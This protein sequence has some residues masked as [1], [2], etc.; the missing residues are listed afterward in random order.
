MRKASATNKVQQTYMDAKSLL[1]ALEEREAEIE[2]SYIVAH[3]ITNP[4]GSTPRK[5][6]LH[7]GRS[8][9]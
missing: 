2:K 8:R 6:L 5:D 1:Q 3:G 4:D 9:F 7:R